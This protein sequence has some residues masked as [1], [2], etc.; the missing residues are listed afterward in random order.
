MSQAA[1]CPAVNEDQAALAT[2]FIKCLVR[3]VRAQV[4]LW[5]PTKA[6]RIPGCWPTSSSRRNGV[7]QCPSIGDPDPDA[8][9]R[10]DMFYTAV[11]IGAVRRDDIA[12]NRDEIRG[13][14]G[15][16]F[17]RSGSWSFCRDVH[18]FGFETCRQLTDAGRNW[19]TMRLQLSPTWRGR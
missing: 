16:C 18:Q 2:P 7:V 3:L 6:N 8:L 10:P 1:L 4:F 9:W 12:N 13:A 17:S 11:G 19:S 14:T 5:G 15:V